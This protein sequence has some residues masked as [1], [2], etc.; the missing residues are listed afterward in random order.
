M[1]I[2]N[3]FHNG[4]NKYFRS[5]GPSDSDRSNWF[6]NYAGVLKLLFPGLENGMFY[7]TEIAKNTKN[8]FQF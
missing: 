2:T 5:D 1:A 7:I 3:V 4:K 6:K 8:Y